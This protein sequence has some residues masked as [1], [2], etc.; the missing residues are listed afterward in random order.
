VLSQKETFPEFTFWPT[1]QMPVGKSI[2]VLQSSYYQKFIEN[3]RLVVVYRG[4]FTEV[5]V[6]VKPDGPIPPIMIER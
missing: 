1:D 4:K 3:N 6:A 2:Y 5:V